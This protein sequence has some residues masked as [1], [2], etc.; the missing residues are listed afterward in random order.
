MGIDY[1]GSFPCKVR[2]SVSDQDLLRMGKAR[3]RA[4][5]ALQHAGNAP[6]N[7]DTGL[8]VQIVVV[9]REGRQVTEARIHDLLL[10]AAPLSALAVHCTG[11][12][13]NIAHTD[14]GCGGTI[15]Y[16]ISARA[17][18][19]LLTRLPD[20]LKSPAG[21]LFTHAVTEFG[22]D[23]AVIDA[24]RDRQDFY[25]AEAAAVREWDRPPNGKLRVTSSQILQ[26]SFT[27]GSLQPAHAKLVAF[28]LGFLDE[29]GFPVDQPENRPLPDDD[30]SI[31]E[32]KYF[33]ACAALA[34]ATNVSVM[35]DA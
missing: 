3:S 25:A 10:E 21:V 30:P 15:H 34:G 23:G 19:W 27:V 9:G 31:T 4:R 2:K 5:A 14:F 1:Y 22:F 35:I 29:H 12:P 26:M 7:E 17:E 6:H 8:T 32:M 18:Q 28:F 16:P 11:C 24:V 20:D 13:A 33:F